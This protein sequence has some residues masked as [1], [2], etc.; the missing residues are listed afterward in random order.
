[1]MQGAQTRSGS[2]QLRRRESARDVD[3]GVSVDVDVE[4]VGWGVVEEK[5]LE[6]G[7]VEI[8]VHEE[9]EGYFEIGVLDERW[10]NL[11]GLVAKA[12]EVRELVRVMAR[13]KRLMSLSSSEGEIGREWG[14]GGRIEERGRRGLGGRRL[15]QMRLRTLNLGQ[16]SI[17][18]K[19]SIATL[20]LPLLVNASGLEL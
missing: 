18:V 4:E 5:V 20:L 16:S 9:K 10:K 12:V 2:W 8:G 3:G 19:C 6:G 11:E 1:M 15:T 14:L 7:E 17:E 13:L